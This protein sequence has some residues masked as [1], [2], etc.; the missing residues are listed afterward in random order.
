MSNE[1]SGREVVVPEGYEAQHDVWHLAPAYRVGNT[2]YCSGQLGFADDGTLPD[3]P[4]AQLVNA[5]EHVKRVLAGAGAELTDVVKLTTYH[6]G[7]AAQLGL[8]A[9]VRDR[10]FS[11]PYAAQTAIG[12]AEL[13]IPGAIVEIDATAVISSDA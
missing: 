13:G 12:V 10:Y 9:Q 7:L 6:V 2:V 5:F 3:D 4:E 1:R 11:P 8:F